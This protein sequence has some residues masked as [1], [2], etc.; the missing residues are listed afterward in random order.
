M[1]YEENKLSELKI[2]KK[3]KT[4]KI[5]T[6]EEEGDR[7]TNIRR[8]TVMDQTR[9]VKRSTLP[10]SQKKIKKKQN[11]CRTNGMGPKI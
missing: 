6:K 7:G 10:S 4:K 5:I 1:L 9:Q 8:K 11:K 3:K 2:I